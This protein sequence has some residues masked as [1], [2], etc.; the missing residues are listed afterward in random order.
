MQEIPKKPL[1]RK[2]PLRNTTAPSHIRPSASLR[3]ATVSP[4][5]FFGSPALAQLNF[6]N[7]PDPTPLPTGPLWQ[8]LLLENPLPLVALLATAGVVLIFLFNQR[9]D[10]RRGLKL[11]LPAL[12]AAIGLWVV[13][14]AVNTD[15]E[16]LKKSAIGLVRAVAS[17][18]AAGADRALADDAILRTFIDA[19]GL[20]K[21]RILERVERDFRKGGSLEVKEHAILEIQAAT[22]GQSDGFVQFKLRATPQATG[23]PTFSW[24]RIDLTRDSS[25][26]WRTTGIDLLESSFGRR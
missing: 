3:L 21:D 8:R 25:G 16:R 24:W 9:G 12:L 18:D 22:Q 20:Q 19:S 15:R 7:I 5:A 1:R 2:L 4:L 17:G 13:A 26:E 11:G 14:S 23:G 6:L 10:M